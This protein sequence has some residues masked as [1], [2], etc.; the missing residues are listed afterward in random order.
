[1]ETKN[2]EQIN[3]EFF[4]EAP[5]TK[6]VKDEKK[7][8]E[9]GASEKVEM[10]KESIITETFESRVNNVT[11]SKVNNVIKSKVE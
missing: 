10:G 4:S 8:F 3:N 1:M 11:D 2:V 9:F 7:I 5:E 6:Q